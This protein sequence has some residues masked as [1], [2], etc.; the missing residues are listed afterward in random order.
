MR[1]LEE[2]E[3]GTMD[4]VEA[5]ARPARPGT[6]ELAAALLIV[7]GVLGV[8]GFFTASAPEP[9]G[10]VAVSVLTLVLNLAQIAVGLFLRIGRLWLFAV[11]YVAVLAFLDLLASGAS[12][13]SLMLAVAEIVVVV[14]LFAQRPWFDAMRAWRTWRAERERI[15][16]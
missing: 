4:A 13:L 3:A 5:P 16:P 6:I 8:V 1:A 15:S 7:G 10:I 9:A 11:N 2:L 14:I 12:P